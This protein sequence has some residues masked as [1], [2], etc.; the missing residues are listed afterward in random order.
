MCHEERVGRPH[1]QAAVSAPQGD[2]SGG[3]GADLPPGHAAFALFRTEPSPREQ[4]AEIGVALPVGGEQQ[5]GEEDGFE[6]RARVVG[7]DR[8]T[9]RVDPLA[10]SLA[11]LFPFADLKSL[12]FIMEFVLDKKSMW[13]QVDA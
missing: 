5:A 11:S 9:D 13:R 8:L 6:R 12:E 10:K 3:V 7:C 4:P 2:E 1:Q